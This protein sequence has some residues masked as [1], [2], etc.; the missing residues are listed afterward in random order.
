MTQKLIYNG[1]KRARKDSCCDKLK[2][3]NWANES[4]ID[5]SGFDSGVSVTN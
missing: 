2:K 3:V 1:G 4:E 5:N